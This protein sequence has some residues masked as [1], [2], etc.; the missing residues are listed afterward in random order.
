MKPLEQRLA[1]YLSK[2]F[3]SQTRHQRFVSD[4]ARALP[5]EA[6][7]ADNVRAILAKAAH[8]L[9]AKRV[10]TL[11]SFH[12][13]RSR[14]NGD[15]LVVFE[16]AVRPKQDYRIPR[17]AALSLD[18]ALAILVDDIAEHV[19]NRTD[20][21]WWSKCAEVLGGDLVYQGLS[22]LKDAAQSHQI[23]NR[24]AFLTRIF[25]DLARRHHLTI[26]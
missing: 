21:L 16:R 8:G 10:P 22:Q 15:W 4:L 9:L 17:Q 1:I 14:R 7:R 24:G 25:K 20:V 26:H 23:R 12:F 11:K 19:G 13:E 3:M 6:N 5:I 2:K 18:P